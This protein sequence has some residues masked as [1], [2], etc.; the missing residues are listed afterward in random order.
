MGVIY[1]RIL[2]TPI[3]CLVLHHAFGSCA[4]A[5]NHFTKGGPPLPKHS[6][7]TNVVTS[8]K[9]FFLIFKHWVFSIKR[10]FFNRKRPTCM[11]MQVCE[12]KSIRNT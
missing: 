7:Y 8:P 9:I 5:Y 11:G 2:I 1:L 12:K 10:L 4:N 3:R 6:I